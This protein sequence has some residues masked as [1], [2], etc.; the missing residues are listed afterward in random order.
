MDL[1][2]LLPVA[3][4]NRSCDEYHDAAKFIYKPFHQKR[5]K[6]WRFDLSREHRDS[7]CFYFQSQ[8]FFVKQS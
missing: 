4:R 5:G 1:R 8:F 3:T 6:S 7:S 2:D